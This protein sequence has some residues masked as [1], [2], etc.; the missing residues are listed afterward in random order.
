MKRRSNF[1]LLSIAFAM[2][3]LSPPPQALPWDFSRIFQNHYSVPSPEKTLMLTSSRRQVSKRKPQTT[4]KK[5]TALIT[6]VSKLEKKVT[7]LQ[8]QVASQ[9]QYIAKLKQ[10]ITLHSTG[11]VT[12]R[13]KKNLELKGLGKVFLNGSKIDMKAAVTGAHGLFKADT[14]YATTMKAKSYAPGAGNIW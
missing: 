5:V 3:L 10:V 4:E 1:T 8:A 14:I 9:N 6:K 11:T 12:L 13:A 2:F 7:N